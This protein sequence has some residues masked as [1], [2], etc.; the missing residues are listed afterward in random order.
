LKIL[1]TGASGFIG[2]HLVSS[3]YRSSSHSNTHQHEIIC[4]T[5]SPESIGRLAAQVKVIK[6]DVSNYADLLKALA[7]I[8]LAFYLI[9]SMEGSSKDWKKFVERDRNAAENFDVHVEFVL[10]LR[11]NP[12]I[13]VY[14]EPRTNQSPIILTA[15]HRQPP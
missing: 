6:A 10:I 9:H 4:M 8:D 13:Q 11:H 7:G 15:F 5:R 3:L 14:K 2:S 1:I 12:Q